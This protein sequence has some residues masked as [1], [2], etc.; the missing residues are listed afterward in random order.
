MKGKKHSEETKAKLSAAK[1][2]KPGPNK[3]IPKTD[4]QKRKISE[5]LM[6]KLVGEKNPFFGKKHTA[7]TNKKNSDAHKGKPSPFKG[8]PRHEWVGEGKK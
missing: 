3:G 2:G 1:I 4:E 8:R 6:G 5:T 7:E